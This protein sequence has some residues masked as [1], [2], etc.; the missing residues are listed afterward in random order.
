MKT[1]EQKIKEIKK[2]FFDECCWNWTE[3]FIQSM[4]ENEEFYIAKVM[5]VD[6]TNG[7][8]RDI[9]FYAVDISKKLTNANGKII[10]Q[11]QADADGKTIDE[12]ISNL[13]NIINTF[14]GADYSVSPVGL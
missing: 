13:L 12:A 11:I 3:V 2:I 6:T 4:T 8:Y 9:F 5:F 1:S 14:I 7:S 10:T